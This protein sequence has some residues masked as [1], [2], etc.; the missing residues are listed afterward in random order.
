VL[1]LKVK[2]VLHWARLGAPAHID[3]SRPSAMDHGSIETIA[4]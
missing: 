2:T 4:R 3:Q 1:T